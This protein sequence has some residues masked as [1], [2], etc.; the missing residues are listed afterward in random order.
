MCGA[1]I[2]LWACY[3]KFGTDIGYAATR[4]QQMRRG[5]CRCAFI[6]GENDAIFGESDAIFAGCSGEN[7][8]VG[9]AISGAR[10]ANYGGG[11]DIYG[12]KWAQ[13]SSELWAA[14]VASSLPPIRACYAMSGTEIA[15]VRSL[16]AHA[17]RCP[18]LRVS[19]ANPLCACYGMSS[20][21]IGYA[22]TRWGSHVR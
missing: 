2:G 9:G 12:R 14:L 11:A 15:S 8:V 21:E 5:G 13:R 19:A 16:Y 10:A 7:A 17:T 20:T 3:A 6:F 22:P 1:T 18:V 4:R